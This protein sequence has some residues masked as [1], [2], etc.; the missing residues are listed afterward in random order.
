MQRLIPVV[1]PPPPAPF[2][3]SLPRPFCL[4]LVAV[5]L[6]SNHFKLGNPII[7]PFL[8]DV[9]QF[10]P[11]ARVLT[12]VTLNA[13]LSIPPLLLHVG[14]GPLVDW[15]GRFRLPRWR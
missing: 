2:P 9:V 5:F 4:A 1:T 8:Q 11:L 13:P 3:F 7:K 15:I 14:V 12:G 10:V 6:S